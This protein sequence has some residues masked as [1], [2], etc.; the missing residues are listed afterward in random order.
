M[1]NQDYFDSIRGAVYIP[2][3]AYNAF[4]QWRDYSS[5]VAERDLGF[6]QS[7]N[8]NSLR[9]WVSYEYWSVEPSAFERKF[10]DFLCIADK[11]G[12]RVMPSLFECC[13]REP[14]VEYINDTDQFTGTAVRSPGTEITND[15]KKWDVPFGFV[16]WFLDRYKDDERLLAIEVT[17]E[18]KT[19]EDHLWGIALLKRVKS[20]GGT[21][22]VT[23]GG[24]E[25]CDNILYKDYIDIYQTHENILLSEFSLRSHLSRMQMI[26]AIDKK[27]VWITEWQRLRK[28]GVGFDS[29]YVAQEELRPFHASM[30]SLYREYKIGNFVW[31]LMLKPAYLTGQR[32]V[33]TFSGLF[34]EDGSVYSL[35]DAR[36]VSGNPNIVLPEKHVLP[37][38]F[39]RVA[40]LSE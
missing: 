32:K 14:H 17:N 18:P 40:A 24:Q 21:V 36:A 27:P 22:P 9:I 7:V 6:A 38:C 1:L 23:L 5:E 8:I 26:E 37:D 11:K 34:H 16:D 25:L 28:S 35:E 4:Q 19:V 13:G 3:R 39:D 33:G 31:S 20:A 10:E 12:M 30:A 15:E 2:T 29:E